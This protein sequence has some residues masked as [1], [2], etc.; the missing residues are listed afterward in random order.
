MEY[1]FLVL[2]NIGAFAALT[3]LGAIIWH[4]SEG[5]AW[6][7]IAIAVFMIV[8]SQIYM[9]PE[10]LKAQFRNP[11]YDNRETLD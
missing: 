8:V 7:F 5:A 11:H 6:V 2:S 3:G 1:F 4:L 9:A 10:L